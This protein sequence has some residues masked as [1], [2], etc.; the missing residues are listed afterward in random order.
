MPEHLPKSVKV[1]RGR[2]LAALERELRRDYLAQLVG[3]PLR[4]LVESGAAQNVQRWVGTSCRYAPV[5]LPGSEQLRGQLID[6]TP[7]SVH[8]ELLLA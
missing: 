1:D 8:D 5:E 2:R 7:H 4:V 6:C 3:R